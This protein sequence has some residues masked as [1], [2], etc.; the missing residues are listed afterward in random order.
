M[1]LGVRVLRRRPRGEQ[2]AAMIATLL[3]PGTGPTTGWPPRD[4]I[5]RTAWHALVHAG[6]LED[7]SR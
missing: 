4:T 6:E 5:R 3:E 1:S 7:K 2:R